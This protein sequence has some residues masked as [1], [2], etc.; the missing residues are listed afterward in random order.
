MLQ[1]MGVTESDTAEQLNHHHP[2]NC[3]PR[4]PVFYWAGSPYTTPST[5]SP[6]WENHQKVI[7][8][9]QN[10]VESMPMGKCTNSKV[11]K[12]HQRKLITMNKKLRPNMSICKWPP[13]ACSSR[14]PPPPRPSTLLPSPCEAGSLSGSLTHSHTHSSMN[15]NP[16]V[17]QSFVGMGTE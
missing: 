12:H 11:R 13:P 17:R 9:C 2:C 3:L 1:S 6:V 8:I 10:Q 15:R 14:F 4:W 7:R 16:T 5:R